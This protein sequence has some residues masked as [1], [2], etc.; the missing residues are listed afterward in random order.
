LQLIQD[1]DVAKD[2]P[3]LKIILASRFGR[4]A[5]IEEAKRTPM[6]RIFAPQ[7]L[8]SVTKYVFTKQVP[9][10]GVNS[11]GARA[12]SIPSGLTPAASL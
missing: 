8:S 4:A 6:N 11:A 12:R 9:A 7:V 2:S 10:H 3:G 1:R 5:T